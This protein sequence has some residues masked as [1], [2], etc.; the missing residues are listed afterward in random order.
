MPRYYFDRREG[1]ELIPDEEGV[2]FSSLARVQE[3]IA[4]RQNG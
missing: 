3:E 4:P 1:T 2:E